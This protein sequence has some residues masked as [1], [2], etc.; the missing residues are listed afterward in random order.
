MGIY[1]STF[2]KRNIPLSITETTQSRFISLFVAE[3]HVLVPSTNWGKRKKIVWF[4]V[5]NKTIYFLFITP[6]LMLESRYSSNTSLQ[7]LLRNHQNT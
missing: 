7:S 4:I 6:H 5:L 3:G 1:P 2:G